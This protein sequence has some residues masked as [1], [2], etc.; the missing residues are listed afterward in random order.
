V[1]VFDPKL[2]SYVVCVTHDPRF[3]VGD[4]IDKAEVLAQ[5]DGNDG[6]PD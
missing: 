4:T 6:D 3:A 2:D 1:A 5:H